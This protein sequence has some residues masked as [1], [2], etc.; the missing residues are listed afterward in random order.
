V[1]AYRTF[2]Q[3]SQAIAALA[4]ASPAVCETFTLAQPSWEGTVISGLHIH[5]GDAKGNRNGVL[6]LGGV[7]ARELMNPEAIVD[8]AADLLISYA[9]DTGITYAVPGSTNAGPGSGPLGASWG[10]AEIGM[11]LE[12]LDIWM[13]PCSNPDG[14][15]YVLST[16]KMWRKNRHPEKGSCSYGPP[17]GVDLNRNCDIVWGVI[18]T[19]PPNQP[20]ATSCDPCDCQVYNGT[21]PFSEPESANIQQFL[22]DHPIYTFAD[23]HSYEQLI[24]YPWGHAP[25]QT[26]D[27]A[28]N[29]T[30]LQTGT[31]GPIPDSSYRE[32]IDPV[33]LIWYQF[34]SNQIASD[35]AKVQ[36]SVY[37]VE[38][39]ISLYPTT[40]TN[41]DYAYSRHIVDPGAHKTYG[42]T[43]ETGPF[44]NDNALESF[45]PSDPSRIILDIKAAMLSLLMQSACPVEL[46]AAEQ[47]GADA[48]AAEDQLTGIRAWRDALG[49]TDAGRAWL[50]LYRQLHPTILERIAGDEGFRSRAGELVEI[51][52]ALAEDPDSV[53]SDDH[54]RSGLAVIDDLAATSPE[55]LR[56]QL[57]TARA[58]FQT[59]SGF[60]VQ[61][62]LAVVAERSPS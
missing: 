14:H 45:Q 49:Q 46:I 50:E 12:S 39:S 58:L 18:P 55:H 16:D 11:M 24:L 29:F 36:G 42:W 28:E 57:Q 13:V 62:A 43:I 47:F 1:S 10:A 17:V 9:N 33:D 20:P 3:L 48:E 60:S 8:L 34:I 53:L 2:A 35:V 59:M 23:V 25:G 7:H 4:G 31:C 27:P 22:S 38:P 51:A 26:T 19:P 54:I 32:Y 41:P 40:G 6:L 44:V 15:D 30:T 56:I 61:A 21:E 52:V 5:A 37:I